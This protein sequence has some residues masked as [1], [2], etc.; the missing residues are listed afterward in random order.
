[1]LAVLGVVL[2]EP[3]DAAG[4]P[5]EWSEA[6]NVIALGAGGL[7]FLWLVVRIVAGKG[8]GPAAVRRPETPFG[9]ETIGALGL[10]FLVP[11]FVAVI[12][13]LLG[14][15]QGLPFTVIVLLVANPLIVFGSLL[16]W[17]KAAWRGSD[18]TAPL[19][20]W[21]GRSRAD[22]PEHLLAFRRST[23]G[24]DLLWGGG[25]ALAI[26]WPL[27]GATKLG[28]LAL[29]AMEATPALQTLV[30]QTIEEPS[31]L[32]VVFTG[33]VVIVLTPLAEEMVYRGFLY[34]GL[35]RLVG[36]WIA[37]ASSALIFSAIH[38]SAY[39]AL[40]LFGIGLALAWIYERTAS[41]AAPVALHAVFN[42]LQFVG[43]LVQ[44]AEAG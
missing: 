16:L 38:G 34:T 7:A 6:W 36:P 33:L 32:T 18:L 24:R 14:G 12:V 42:A 25:L 27:S 37:A 4:E 44:R 11:G 5:G 26:L 19:V 41:L 35:R 3:I 43:I 28:G 1:M 21:R 9:I 39:G 31:H 23:L 10:S 30:A 13:G 20:D 15:R 29:R 17:R 2:P 8:W 40:A 22:A